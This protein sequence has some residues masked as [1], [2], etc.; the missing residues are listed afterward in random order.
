MIKEKLIPT[1]TSK[2]RFTLMLYRIWT[3]SLLAF[4]IVWTP[5]FF[6]KKL[7]VGEE[8]FLYIK[9]FHRLILLKELLLKELLLKK[10]QRN[11]LWKQKMF[12]YTCEY[13]FFAWIRNRCIIFS[14][15]SV[16]TLNSNKYFGEESGWRIVIGE[17]TL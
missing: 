17:P 5:K 13:E 8:V 1:Y 3:R 15:S 7:F 14:T 12:K 2:A 11:R 4:L 6:A 9:M 16:N 10:Y